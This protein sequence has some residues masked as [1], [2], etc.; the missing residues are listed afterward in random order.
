MMPD[1]KRARSLLHKRLLP[2]YVSAFFHNFVLWYTIEK[3]FMQNIGFS[4]TGIGLMIALYSA[5]ML[6]VEV[7]SG[8]LA[9]RWS[10]KGMLV[11]ASICLALSAL[12]GGLS[13]GIGLYLIAAVLWGTF[14]ACYSGLYDTIV[15]D[16]IAEAT[17]PSK[18]FDRLYGRVQLI[19]SVALILAGLLGAAVASATNLRTV[20]FLS[21]PLALVPIVALLRFREPTLHKQHAIIPIRQQVRSTVQAIVSNRSLGPVIAVL[22]LRSTLFYCIA[23]FA[24]LWLLALHTP[25]AYY[26]LASAVLFAS[27]GVGGALVSRLRLSR[28]ARMAGTLAVILLAGLGLIFLRSTPGIVLA[29]AVFAS[30]LVCV[31]I[32]FSR[33]LHDNLGSSIRAGA[34]SASS[35]AGR[36]LI[37]PMALLIGY[38]SQK[39]TIYKAAYIFLGLAILM[40]VFVIHVARRDG[41]TGLESTNSKN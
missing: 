3:L 41:R 2:L 25:T 38:V 14:Y 31:Y 10:R 33:I 12:F 34:A 32:I 6:V 35:T 8:I 11:V 9:D 7:P 23:E 27:L 16:C 20:Y 13:H 22:V 26:G 5:I 4:N 28:Y 40:T 24:Q 29:Q 36:L 1:E 30:G 17:A 21:V 18:L 37:I 15:Y 39:F 19:D